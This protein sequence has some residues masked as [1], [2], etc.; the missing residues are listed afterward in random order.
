VF[1][2]DQAAVATGGIHRNHVVRFVDIHPDYRART[3]VSDICS[4]LNTLTTK[5]GEPMH[6]TPDTD[7][8]AR[9]GDVV[10]TLQLAATSG[11]LVTVPHPAGDYVHLQLRR[12]A[13]CPIC[14]LHLRSI[15][16]RHDEIRSHGIREVVVFHS[17]AAELVKH[18]AELPFPLI[19][20][21]ERMLYRRFGVKRRPRSVLSPRPLGAAIAGLASALRKHSTKRGPLGPVKPTGGR[22]GLPAD[23]LIAPD[24]RITALKYGRH[25]YDQWTVEEL[26]DHA[27]PMP[28]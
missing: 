2:S 23:F 21:P 18:E 26:L 15:V 22:L 12:F 3:E 20:D 24:G 9:V 1:A 17:T 5:T 7:D 25:A 10:P 28:A 11:Q 4:A 16:T 19:A 14:N 13:G 6:T 8:K 27:R